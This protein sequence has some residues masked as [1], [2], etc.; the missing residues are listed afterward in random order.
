MR[1]VISAFPL[2]SKIVWP[3]TKFY[4]KTLKLEGVLL[5]EKSVSFLFKKMTLPNNRQGISPMNN[6]FE[7]IENHKNQLANHSFCQ[8]LRNAENPDKSIF[9]FVPHMTFFVLGFRDLL[10]YLRVPFPSNPVEFMLNEHCSEDSDHWL[11]FLQDLEKL[12]LSAQA[13]G[14]HR[15]ADAMELIWAPQNAA[16]RRQ[17]YD[18]VVLIN[19]CKNAQE[20]LIIVECLEAAFAA[21]IESLNILTKRL[22]IYHQLVYFGEHHYDKE[23]EHTMGSWLESDVPKKQKSQQAKNVIRYPVMEQMVDDIF[24]GFETMFSCW[25]KAMGKTTEPLALA[26]RN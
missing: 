22:G 25:E 5:L 11:W 3:I 16:I 23:S 19:H 2:R 10:E 13:W 4:K 15:I 9:N 17:I 8:R 18:I 12:Q 20:K 14:G 6:I 1:W 21:F 7:L 26:S 24:S